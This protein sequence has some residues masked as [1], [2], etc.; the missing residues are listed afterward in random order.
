MV[1]LRESNYDTVDSAQIA[2]S[3]TLPIRVYAP[4]QRQLESF[5]RTPLQV[6]HLAKYYP[7]VPGGI[8]THVQAIAR[9]QAALGMQVHVI[10][11]NGTTKAIHGATKTETVQE[12]DNGVRV[13]R[14]GRSLTVARFDYCPELSAYLSRIP[15]SGNTVVHLHTPNP[16]M[17]MAL[18]GWD[19]DIP[20]V[21]TH[22]SDLIKQRVLKYAIRPFE[23]WVYQR[24]KR[25]LT[26]SAAYIEGSKFLQL[27]RN[28]LTALPLGLDLSPYTQP[29]NSAS[30]EFANRLRQKY[31]S[32]PI[33]L[34]VGRLVYYKALHISIQALTKVPGVL[35]VIGAGPLSAE[36]QKL[37]QELGV[38]D[39]VI[40][41]GQ[42]TQ[43]ELIGAYQAATALWF[44]SNERSEG[45]GLVQ[46]EAMA[47]GCPVINANIPGSG[48]TWVSRHEQEGLTVPVNDAD[49]LAAA[50]QRL[51]SEPGLRDKLVAASRNRA[52]EFDHLTMAQRSLAIYNQVMETE[53]NPIAIVQRV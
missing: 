47:S 13:T 46:V 22:H 43:D 31:G 6:Y 27:Y 23:H 7:P 53:P 33:W 25:V 39:R 29:A 26:T 32:A 28:K 4:S 35:Y 50:A 36:L 11:I 19:S 5:T 48:V 18:Q 1:K 52:T 3:V 21:V 44:P 10:C 34:A 17:L 51:I 37:A 15:T 16:A 14:V 30:T 45:F 20:L 2:E 8:E 12:W 38:S 9:A 49:A 40:W 24:A 41:H 42:A